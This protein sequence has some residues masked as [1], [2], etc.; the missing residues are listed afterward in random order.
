MAVSGGSTVVRNVLSDV[1]PFVSVAQDIDW[2]H[3]DKQVTRE[4]PNMEREWQEQA[5]RLK[6]MPEWN[7]FE[8]LSMAIAG[9]W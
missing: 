9:K 4:L 3:L 1:L 7:R 2:R 8:W 6:K 5:E